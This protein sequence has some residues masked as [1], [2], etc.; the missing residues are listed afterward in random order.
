MSELNDTGNQRRHFNIVQTIKSRTT[1]T[2]YD[3][4]AS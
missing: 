4:E 2:Q 3:K 1:T